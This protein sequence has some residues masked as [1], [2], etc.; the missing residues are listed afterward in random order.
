M[1]AGS[2]SRPQSC[3]SSRY[4]HRGQGA[5]DPGFKG[6]VLGEALRSQLQWL[7]HLKLQER[8]AHDRQDRC[9]RLQLLTDS[10]M[11]ACQ[12]RLG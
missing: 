2:S 5:R 10:V 1:S 11:I 12:G 9:I 4:V 7:L 3:S 8:M 6:C